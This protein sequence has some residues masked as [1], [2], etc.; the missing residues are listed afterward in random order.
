MEKYERVY[1]EFWKD[2]VEENGKV[3]LDQIK[4]E[5]A[6]YR[7]LLNDVPKVYEEVCGLSKAN[8][9]PDYVINYLNDHYIVKE[10]A[11]DDLKDFVED[12]YISWEDI[13]EYLT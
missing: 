8:T 9:R 10:Y 13:K 11:L 1:D 3:N 6:D 2:I 5:L 12:G 4:R 7:Q